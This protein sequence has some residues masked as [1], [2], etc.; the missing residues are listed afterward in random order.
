[1]IS[2]PSWRLLCNQLLC[3]LDLLVLGLVWPQ[4]PV[5]FR[6]HARIYSDDVTLT[7]I[8]TIF[9]Y[10]PGPISWPRTVH[11]ARS[12]CGMRMMAF[13]PH[14]GCPGPSS[15]LPTSRRGPDQ[16]PPWWFCHQTESGVTRPLIPCKPTCLY[17]LGGG[18]QS[19]AM[20]S[21]GPNCGPH[22]LHACIGKYAIRRDFL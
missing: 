11:F 18:T 22:F 9:W 5:F 7:T 13:R 21:E 17:C 19:G 8:A 12:L 6:R 3:K 4:L 10:V 16:L 2:L 15:P 20:G 1:M 14:T